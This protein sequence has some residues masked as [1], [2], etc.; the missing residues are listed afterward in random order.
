MKNKKVRI[1]TDLGIDIKMEING[2]GGVI[3]KSNL[4]EVIGPNEN[5]RKELEKRG[6]MNAAT[7]VID[8]LEGLFMAHAC[9]GV[10]V[11]SP[12][13]RKGIDIGVEAMINNNDVIENLIQ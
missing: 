8:L 1:K 6:F 10:D 12:A 7:A 9:A 3:L 5:D 4:M 2:E 11:T 13:Y